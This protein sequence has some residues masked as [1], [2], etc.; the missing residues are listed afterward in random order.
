MPMLD[1]KHFIL[2]F[3]LFQ[4]SA[5]S[6]APFTTHTSG[7]S[8]GDAHWQINT[9]LLPTLGLSI[10]RGIS[11]DFYAG[12]T[13]EYQLGIVTSL[14]GKYSFINSP[15]D[16]AFAL[17][18]G[19]FQGASLG[20]SSGYYIGPVVS[21]AFSRVELY[22]ALRY[23]Q[24][25]WKAG[26]LTTDEQDQALIELIDWVDSRFAYLQTDVGLNFWAKKSLGINLNLKFLSFLNNSDI[27]TTNSLLPGFSFIFAF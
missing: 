17:G 15:Q 13:A 7:R 14:W 24:V 10:G 20:D 16:F 25:E 2:L 5:C 3:L 9:S 8:I 21:Y 18:A 27:A 11:D 26:S 1:K 22:A 6:L 19:Y 4:I 12:V 23:N